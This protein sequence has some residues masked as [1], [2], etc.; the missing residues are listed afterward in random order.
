MREG[1]AGPTGTRIRLIRPEE[2]DA[3]RE[4]LKLGTTGIEEDHFK[5]LAEDRC[6]GHLLAGLDGAGLSME[7][8][9]RA[10]VSG[11]RADAWFGMTLPLGAFDREGRMVGA[12]LVLP[13]SRLLQIVFDGQ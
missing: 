13:P 12:L 8:L 4:L 10:M 7:N 9:V 3:A 5:A 6:A 11:D 2:T 1:L